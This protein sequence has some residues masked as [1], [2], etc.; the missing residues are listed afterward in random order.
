[1]RIRFALFS[2]GA[3]GAVAWFALGPREAPADPA[4]ALPA[5]AVILLEGAPEGTETRVVLRVP[6]TGAQPRVLGVVPHVAGSARRGTLAPGAPARAYVVAAERE[7]RRG[8]TYHSALWRVQEGSAPARLRG[9]LT[10]ASRPLVTARGTLLVQSGSDGDEPV[11]DGSRAL[12]ERVDALTLDAVDPANGASRT[13]WRGRGMIAFLAAPL[14]DDEALVYH[15]DA[16][17]AALFALDAATGATRPIVAQMEPLARDFSYDA[18]RDEVTFARAS[19][20]HDGTWEVVSVPAR[21]PATP[22]D[23]ARVRWRADSDHLMPRALRGGAVVISLPGDRGLARLD[24]W[25]ALPARVAPLGDGA[26]EALGE[27]ADGRWLCLRHRAPGRELIA[28]HAAAEGRTVT[29]DRPDVYAEFVG[30]AEVA[31]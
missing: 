30:F 22:A 25:P 23:R 20:R 4:R 14:K 2:L 26:D 3:V 7:S 9:G 18:A 5:P 27:S 10:D 13:L 8:S 24:A 21:G 16:G 1:M 17:G 12:R 28:L 15:V 19:L 6:A 31:P 29:L 11:P